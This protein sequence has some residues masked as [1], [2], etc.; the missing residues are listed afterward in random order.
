MKRILLQVANCKSRSEFDEAAALALRAPDWHGRNLDA[1]WDS[2]TADN[3]NG[4]RAP[5]VLSIEGSTTLPTD[6]LDYVRRFAALFD[7]AGA[8]HPE[9]VVRC[10]ISNE[11]RPVQRRA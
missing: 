11:T 2:I 8:L 1:W 6:V 9:L 7:E 5:Y 10:E 4:V 3:I